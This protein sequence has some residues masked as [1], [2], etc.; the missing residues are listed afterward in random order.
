MTDLPK[1]AQERREMML[2]DRA[3]AF[4]PRQAAAVARQRI[5]AIAE[6]E[7]HDN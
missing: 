3:P 4:R 5:A 1:R 7:L 2:N 6:G